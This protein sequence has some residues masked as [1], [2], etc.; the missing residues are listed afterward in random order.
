M[1]AFFTKLFWMD[2]GE[3][4]IRA[5]SWAALGL[6]TAD[7]V[8]LVTFDW[9]GFLWTVVVAGVVSLLASFAGF[10]SGNSASLVVDAVPKDRK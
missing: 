10:S 2:A 8:D 3:R 1:S 6:L 7:G 4:S 9:R 5:A